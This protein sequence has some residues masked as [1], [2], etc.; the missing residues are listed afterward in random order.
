MRTSTR[1]RVALDSACRRASHVLQDWYRSATG[2]LASV[3]RGLSAVGAYACPA[4]PPGSSAMAQT[5]GSSAPVS[6]VTCNR[7]PRVMPITYELL[8]HEMFSTMPLLMQTAH[9]V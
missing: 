8:K 4:G 3:L 6:L 7:A 9:A 1:A 5:V 2:E